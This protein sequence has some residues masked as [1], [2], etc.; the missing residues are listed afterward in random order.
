MRQLLEGGDMAGAV[1]LWCAYPDDLLAEPVAQACMALLSAD[2]RARWQRFRFD[3]RRRE[4]LAT[5]AL[6]RRALSANFPL[7]PEAWQF[8]EN[9][10][11]KPSIDTETELGIGSGIGSE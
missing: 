3:K 5:H 2:E 9:A 6:K 4:H 8:T 7:A 1:Q 10:H 11:G